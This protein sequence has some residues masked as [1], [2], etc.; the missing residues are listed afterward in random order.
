MEVLVTGTNVETGAALKFQACDI[1]VFDGETLR[2]KR[3]YR[4]VVM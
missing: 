2:E 4:K 3:S 1:V